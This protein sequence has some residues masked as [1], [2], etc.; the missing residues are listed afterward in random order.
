[1]NEGENAPSKPKP[2]SI[3]EALVTL[4]DATN[5]LYDTVFPSQI[6]GHAREQLGKISTDQ[7]PT[8]KAT[9]DSHIDEIIRNTQVILD[10]IKSLEILK[11]TL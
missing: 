5:L 2:V 8:M 6:P 11:K 1:M 10:V 3:R 4:A 7:P 9:A